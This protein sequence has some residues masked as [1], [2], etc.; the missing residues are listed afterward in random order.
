MATD[1]VES[2]ASG[3][4]QCQKWKT[5]GKQFTN[6]CRGCVFKECSKSDR[7]N[8]QC[9][10]ANHQNHINQSSIA[11]GTH[12]GWNKAM[13]RTEPKKLEE[14]KNFARDAASD[15]VKAGE[16][17]K[18]TPKISSC[19]MN[20]NRTS[21]LGKNKRKS[22]TPKKQSSS[23]KAKS[24]SPNANRTTATSKGD[25]RATEDEQSVLEPIEK[26]C[27]GT[28]K[29][30]N[31]IHNT[32]QESS[33]DGRDAIAAGKNRAYENKCSSHDNCVGMNQWKKEE[34]KHH[35]DKTECLKG[36]ICVFCEKEAKEMCDDSNGHWA[37][38][39][40]MHCNTDL[41]RF[42]NCKGMCEEMHCD[43]LSCID[44]CNVNTV[45]TRKRACRSQ[46][47]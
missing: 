8:S 38:A 32:E 9:Q 37:D 10:K 11:N 45:T 20:S 31:E 25:A 39:C 4:T 33:K 18:C 13:E 40:M 26:D 19:E 43:G 12:N 36:R 6:E 23:K 17:L 35:L 21:D 41:L 16:K 22:K 34:V 46:L 5:L 24:K 44:C 30:N 47:T 27:G 3:V 7:A 28:Q 42:Q 29:R 1:A 2:E 14:M 15:S